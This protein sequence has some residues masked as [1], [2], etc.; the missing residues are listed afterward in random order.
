MI[1]YII[2]VRDTSV[3]LLNAIW[4]YTLDVFFSLT[5]QHE[6]TESLNAN[7]GRYTRLGEWG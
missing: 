6:S 5:D 3:S 2:T 4:L 7:V 1:I